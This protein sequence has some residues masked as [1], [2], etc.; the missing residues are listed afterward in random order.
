MSDPMPSMSAAAPHVDESLV[1]YTHVI[2]ALHALRCSS[3]VTTFH[4]IVASF[5]G[6]LPSIIAVIMNYARRSATRGH[7]PRVALSLAD[8]HLLVRGAV[9]VIVWAVSVRSML[10]PHRFPA[11]FIASPLRSAVDRLPRG[12]WL[13]GAARPASRCTYEAA[14]R[15]VLRDALPRRL[16]AEG[17]AV[18]AG[19]EAEGRGDGSAAARHT[20][21][22]TS[23]QPKQPTD[24]DDPSQP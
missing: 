23:R 3:G 16:R 4:T 13:A 8:P 2:Y 12:A 24:A 10:D 18:P 19:P 6:G 9:G 5:I 14:A 22:A 7:L 20:D 21:A 15:P 17:P 1:T 11:C